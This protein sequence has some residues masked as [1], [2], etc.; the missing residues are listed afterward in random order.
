MVLLN[1]FNRIFCFLGGN[2][3]AKVII[4]Q[5]AKAIDKTFEYAV[6]EGMTLLPGMRVMV[7]FGTRLLQGFTIDE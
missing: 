4:D 6:P 2:L 7:P 3:F 5:D 1:L